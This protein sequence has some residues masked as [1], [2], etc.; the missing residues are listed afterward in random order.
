MVEP[1][2]SNGAHLAKVIIVRWLAL[3]ECGLDTYKQ[4]LQR[5]AVI[6]FI[7]LYFYQT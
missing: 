3:P 2:N 7:T 1:R 6:S 5:L 4:Q